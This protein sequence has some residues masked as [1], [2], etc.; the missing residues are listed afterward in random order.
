MSKAINVTKDDFSD[1][2]LNSNLPVLV[3]FWAPWCGPC[4]AIA[5]ILD[6]LAADNDGKVVLA[7]VDVDNDSS[8]A[9]EYGV[10]GIP[11]LILFHKGEV[12]GSMVGA[13]TK[14]K[15]EDFLQQHIDS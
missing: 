2:V 12:L 8:I 15:I 3:D 11:T 4:K 6:Q 9:S 14:E 1:K 10:R 7:K 5:P 13:A